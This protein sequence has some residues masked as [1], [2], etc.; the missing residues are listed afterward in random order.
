MSD[1]SIHLSAV[2]RRRFLQR[3]AALGLSVPASS[4]LFGA[5][6]ESSASAMSTSSTAIESTSD[7]LTIR[8]IADI[9]NLDPAFFANTSV[10]EPVMSAINEGLVTYKT[11][12]K[13]FEV[14]NQLAET[15]TPSSDG[16]SFDFKLK[17]GILFHGGYGELTAHDVKFTYERLADLHAPKIN[18][19]YKGDWIAL[20]E[21]RVKDKYT[22]TII[23]KRPFAALLHSTLPV[24]SG[25]VLSQKAVEERGKKYA[26]HPIGTGPYEFVRWTPGQKVEL[27]RFKDYKT[28]FVDPPWS[29]IVL[30]PIAQD[31]SADIAI[32]TGAADFGQIGLQ[33]VS[34]FE[35]NSAFGTTSRPTLAFVWI[36]MNVL[37]PK[38]R[39]LNVRKAI[40]SAIDVPSMLQ[41]AFEGRYQ[42]ANAIIPKAMGLGYW[43]AAPVYNRDVQ[44]A[45]S[46]MKA[47]GLSSLDLTFTYTEEPGADAVAQIAQQNLSDIGIK[48]K[49]EKS[50]A[51]TYYELGKKL[52]QRE[53]FWGDYETE[54]DPSFSMVWFTCPQIDQ[55]NWMYSCTKPFDS[56]QAR[57][58]QEQDPAKRNA[59]YIKMQKLMDE[60]AD[61]VW[62]AFSTHYY[63]YR[64]GLDP[65]ISPHGRVLPHAFRKA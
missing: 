17:K 26:T 50:D 51:G 53:L 14:V 16:L 44:K 30:L 57:A 5:Y 3:A 28:G 32:E 45:K 21:V 48:L 4:G 41:A 64:K 63:S 60:T 55:W 13:K 8:L 11:H 29:K 43:P 12:T 40:R 20:K 58:L 18:A 61:A 47:A 54:P 33:S 7:T 27:R 15:F 59:L 42:R 49:L 56:L 6:G 46:Y 23:L 9:T 10:D 19:P 24:T 65:A 36:G 31:N 39:P 35:R 52:R 25:Y 22:G 1:E 34:R 38:L 37:A 62:L 2:D